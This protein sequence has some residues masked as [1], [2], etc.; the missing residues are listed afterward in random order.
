MLR[1][2]MA[3]FAARCHGLRMYPVAKL[4]DR[5]EAV[6]AGSVPFFRARI[7]ARSEG[8]KR[9]PCRGREGDRNAGPC[10]VKGLDDI[11]GEPLESIDVAPWRFPCPE[12]RRE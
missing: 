10:V 5:D 4:D 3:A 2:R 6:S 7:S 9:S 1:G 8:G 12:I 11:P